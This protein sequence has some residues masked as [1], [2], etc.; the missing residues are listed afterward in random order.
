M[1][2]VAPQPMD[3]W[4]TLSW[5]HIERGVLKLQKRIDQAQCRGKVKQVRALQ[6]LLMTSRSAQLLAVRRVTQD[7]QGKKTAGVDGQKS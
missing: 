1:N 4:N 2:T 6:R 5:K 3:G 7:K